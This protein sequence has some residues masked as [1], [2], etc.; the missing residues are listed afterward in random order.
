MY[1]TT[2]YY[3]RGNNKR[4]DYMNLVKEL[5]ELA[6][7]ANEPKVKA[8]YDIL[9]EQFRKIA[10]TGKTHV[11]FSSHYLL[12]ICHNKEV[13]NQIIRRLE[14]FGLRIHVNSDTY[15]FDWSVPKHLYE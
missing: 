2:E 6:R 8:A 1:F 5:R 11:V 3:L 4:N 12:D 14:Y 15:T 9:V 7:E 10:T 13:I